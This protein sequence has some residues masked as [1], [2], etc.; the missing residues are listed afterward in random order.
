MICKRK[1]KKKNST[2]TSEII[3]SFSEEKRQLL[4][5]VRAQ[6]T[7]FLLYPWLTGDDLKCILSLL[8]KL[9]LCERYQSHIRRRRRIFYLNP[10]YS[11]KD[12]RFPDQSTIHQYIFLTRDTDSKILINYASP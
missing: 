6:S 5:A 4:A 2:S 9:G 3:Y 8:R 1:K 11:T 10:S 7:P 12:I